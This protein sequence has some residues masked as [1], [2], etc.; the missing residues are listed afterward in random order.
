MCVPAPGVRVALLVILCVF[1]VARRGWPSQ[2]VHQ[3]PCIQRLGVLAFRPVVAILLLREARVL[4]R[5]RLE[6]L[7][8]GL[9]PGAIEDDR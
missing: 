9:G 8:L 5:L 4:V 1:L 7:Q 6:V 3:S 2:F